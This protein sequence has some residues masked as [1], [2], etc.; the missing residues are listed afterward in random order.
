RPLPEAAV[1]AH[2]PVFVDRQFGVEGVIRRVVFVTRTIDAPVDLPQSSSER[3]RKS[4]SRRR[5]SRRDTTRRKALRRRP[6]P[7]RLPCRSGRSRARHTR[8]PGYPL[9]AT[10]RHGSWLP[11]S[12]LALSRPLWERLLRVS[13][14][15]DTS[16]QDVSN[17]LSD[18]AMRS[19]A[20][21]CAS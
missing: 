21:Q 16:S 14:P 1:G 6:A 15:P 3:T 17:C 2:D 9:A 10:R 11:L 4:S 5:R 12:P 20:A 19:P 8:P 7:P 13:A 18:G